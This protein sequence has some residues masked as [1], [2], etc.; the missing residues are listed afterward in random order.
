MAEKPTQSK[1]TVNRKETACD[2]ENRFPG[3][4]FYGILLA[5]ELVYCALQDCTFYRHLFLILGRVRTTYSQ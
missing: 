5:R 3:T 1:P 2:V 4:E